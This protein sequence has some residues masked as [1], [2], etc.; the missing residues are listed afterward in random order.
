[1]RQT[2]TATGLIIKRH[3]YHEVDRVVTLVT[4]EWGKVTVIAKG[5]RKLTSSKLGLLEPG[6]L[7]KGFFIPTKT[8]SLLTQAQLI[9]TARTRTDSLEQIKNLQLA[10]ELFDRLLIEDELEQS[11]FDQILSIRTLVLGAGSRGEVRQGFDSFL[12]M[13]GYP[14]LTQ[15]GHASV[16]DFVAELTD[17]PLHS[18]D[19][20]E[21]NRQGTN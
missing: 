18:W 3:N 1:M 5:A 11:L 12:T 21:P 15:S 17:R 6:N 7:I 10:L 20:L 2:T 9:Q 4:Q 13:L 8:M 19:F 14:S 16:S